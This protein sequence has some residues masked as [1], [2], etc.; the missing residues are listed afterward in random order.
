MKMEVK[1]MVH[2]F[3]LPEKVGNFIL[4]TEISESGMPSKAVQL[5]LKPDLSASTLYDIGKAC[6]PSP[7]CGYVLILLLCFI[8]PGC[9]LFLVSV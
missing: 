4:G 7:E 1:D 3:S 6:F 9:T 5:N 2:C 8:L